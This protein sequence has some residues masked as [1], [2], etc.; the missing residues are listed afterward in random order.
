MKIVQQ[1]FALWRPGGIPL[2]WKQLMGDKKRFSVAVGGVSF[3]VILMLFQLGIYQAFMLMVARPIDGMR[4]ELAMISRNFNYIMSTEPFPERRL[5]Q[6]MA[7]P[8]VEKVY[9]LLVQFASWRSQKTG[10]NCEVALYGVNAYAN[11]FILPEVLAHADALAMP[12]GALFDE[13]A[14]EEF[15]DV[16]GM[17]EQHGVMSGE[18]NSRHVRVLG[19]FRRGGTLAVNCHVIVGMETFRRVTGYDGHSIDVGMIELKDGADAAET[20]RKLNE[21]LP[22]DIDV[23]TREEFIRKEQFYWQINTPIGFIVTAGMVIAMFVGSVI[24]YQT[25]YTDIN[26]HIREY[27]TLKALGLGSG[28]FLRLIL[29]EAAIL[30]AFG[31]IPGVLCAWLLFRLADSLGG[32]PTRLTVPDTLTVFCLTVLSCIIAGFLATR[33]LRAADPADIF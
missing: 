31:F 13:M 1:W 29:Q 20:A 7:L 14:P 22:D 18:I 19:T 23:L 11:P 10:I 8:E 9:P 2:A 3:G 26:D 25:L 33:R 15:G 24:A 17:L 30:P 12:D 21:L 5:Y 27:A 32:M 4:G 6:T 16:A 28:F